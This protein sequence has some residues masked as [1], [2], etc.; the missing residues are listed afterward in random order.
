M[1]SPSAFNT[2]AIVCLSLSTHTIADIFAAKTI[3]TTIQ[4]NIFHFIPSHFLS[5][6]LLAFS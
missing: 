1:Q 3:A 2:T 6:L 4:L 5:F